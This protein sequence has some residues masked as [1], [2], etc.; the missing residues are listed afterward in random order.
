MSS[1]KSSTRRL[2]E[3]KIWANNI[4]YY[5]FKRLLCSILIFSLQNQQCTLPRKVDY[6]VYKQN[7]GDGQQ[8]RSLIFKKQVGLNLDC[9]CLF[10]QFVFGSKLLQTIIFLEKYLKFCTEF[11]SLDQNFLHSNSIFKKSI[12]LFNLFIKSFLSFS[13]YKSGALCI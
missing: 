5:F 11:Y 3:Q 7:V 4:Y 9:R 8:S 2:V 6:L 1:T 10:W 13:S 12:S